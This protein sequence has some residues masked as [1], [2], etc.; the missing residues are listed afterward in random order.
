MRWGPEPLA[1]GGT[2]FAI[3]APGVEALTLEIEGGDPLPMTPEMEGWFT[4][5]TDTGPGTK[6]RYGLPG[7]TAVPDPASRAQAGDVHGWS[8]VTDS[9]AYE[10]R[11]AD[12]RGRPWTEAVIQEVHVG[13]LGGYAGVA[14][15]L[16]EIAS[17]GFTAIELMPLAA[18]GGLRNWGYD[19]VLPYAPNAAYGSPDELKALIDAAHQRGLMVFLDVVYNHFGPDGNY[20][21]TYAPQFFKADVHTPWGGAI[22]FAREPVARF[23]IDNALYWLGEFGFDGLRLDAV[24]AIGDN[25]FLDQLAGEVRAA[26][27]DRHVHLVLENEDNDPDRLAGRYDAQWNDDFHNVLHVLLT[28]ETHGYYRDFAEDP[29]EKLARCLAE[30]FIYQGQGSPNQKGKPRGSPSGHLSPIRFV[31]FLQNHD[32]IGNRAL[33]ERLTRLTDKARLRAA[34]ALLILCPQVPLTFM[35]DDLG[36][37]APFLFFTDFHD[38]LA[39]AVRD[40]RRAEFAGH[41][42][43]GDEAAREAIPD[44]NARSTFE[45]SDPIPGPDAAEWHALYRELLTIRRERIVPL[46]G[47]TAA[48]GAEVIGD[49]AVR[50]RWRLG[51]AVLTLAINLSDTAVAVSGESELLFATGEVGEPASFAAWLK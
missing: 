2:R 30:G 7:G 26:F 39:D 46:L 18:T 33:G 3:W 37:E 1:G 6:Y 50:A 17:T 42:G 34:T 41:P 43:F 29:A 24:H 9:A 22:D 25:D 10:W 12:W 28:G 15:R 5:D 20:L 27:P 36:S 21:P 31:S 51:E 49:R 8:V 35:G 11:Q 32:Q 16:D 47:D 40:G 14:G 44:P 38:E 23:F 4:A 13:V 19:G 45:A 48:I